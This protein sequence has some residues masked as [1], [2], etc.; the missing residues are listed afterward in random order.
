M[1]KNNPKVLRAWTLYDW[2]NSVYA[3]VIT[4]AIFPI[5]YAAQTTNNAEGIS[6]D[7]VQFFGLQ[8]VNTELMSYMLCLSYLV[9]VILSPILSGIADATGK[10][11]SFMQFFSTLGGLSCMSLYF[12][13]AQYLELSMLPVVLASV[14]FWGSIVFYNSY[15]P[16]ITEPENFDALSAKGYAYG[17]VGSVILLIINLVM[18]MVFN[19]DV[20][21]CFLLVGLWWIGFAQVSFRHLKNTP[22]TKQELDAGVLK[23]GFRELYG[24]FQ[25]VLQL[26]SL[27]IYLLSFFVFSTA[28]QTIMAMAV[29]FGEKE[30]VWPTQEAKSMGLIISILLVQLVAVVGSYLHSWL[31]NRYGNKL[32]LSISLSIW[33]ALCVIGYFV[34]TPNQFYIVAGLIGL[35]FGGIQSLSRSSYSKLLPKTKDLTSFFSFYD[36]TEKVGLIIGVFIYGFLEGL[37]GSM[38]ASIA[39]LTLMFMAGLLILLFVP[40]QSFTAD[41]V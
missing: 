4:S 24:V 20:R 13:D 6:S 3:L 19:I 14:G 31:S 29:Y 34:Y 30:I 41:D 22:G 8:F 21:Y 11:A 15:L 7:V 17:Y 36:V 10:R 12:F 28:V 35:V 37:T 18:I 5:F 27:K 40:K 23:R 39:F 1:Q 38:R 25:K 26:K 33:I 16:L 9:V 2:A 32:A